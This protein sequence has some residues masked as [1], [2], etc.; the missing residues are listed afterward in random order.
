MYV[1][2]KYKCKRGFR[3]TNVTFFFVCLFAFMFPT[4]KICYSVLYNLCMKLQTAA[5][6]FRCMH[7]G[8]ARWRHSQTG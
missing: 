3:N 6:L 4:P 1:F 5:D 7:R 8:T 2:S